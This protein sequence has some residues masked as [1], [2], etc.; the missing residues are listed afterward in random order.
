MSALAVSRSF[1]DRL[2]P[3]LVKEVRQALRGRYFRALFWLTL[4]VA[5]LI[6]LT[7]VAQAG[8]RGASTGVGRSFF[9]LMSGCLSAAVLAFTPFSAFLATSA[10]WDENTHDLLV[11]SNLRPRRIVYGKLLSALVQALLYYSTFS[12]FLVFAFLMNG[13][14]LLSIAALLV[15]SFAACTT[16]ALL[17]IAMASLSPAKAPRVLLMAVFGVVL[18]IAWGFSMSFSTLVTFQPNELRD[19]LALPSIVAFVVACL[20]LGGL[21]AAV[22]IAR[23]SHDEE[24]RSSGLRVLSA[25]IVLVAA[26]FGLWMELGYGHSEIAWALQLIVLLPLALLWLLFVCEPEALGRHVVRHVSPRP[27]LALL[28]APFLPGGGRG[29]ALMALHMLAS[30]GT[31]FVVR[32]IPGADA[33]ELTK[34]LIGLALVYAYAWIY[35]ALPAAIASLLPPKLSTRVL[36]RVTILCGIPMLV[37]LPPLAGLVLGIPS[38]MD[39]LHPLNPLFPLLEL[40][41][42]RAFSSVE[43]SAFLVA[44]VV[45]ILANTPRMTRGFAEV[46]AASRAR[47]AALAR[48]S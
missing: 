34:A 36:T 13:V 27:W 21:F 11:L 35:V 3:I 39:F 6:G 32:L 1:D 9:M 45:A 4:G 10:E 44:T 16:L 14:D 28:S 19:P 47:R 37:L 12:P 18:L 7:I 24:N 2:N 15:T 43:K 41:K 33:P 29:V 22:A 20:L 25:A 31:L 5:T 30:L 48:P 23:L 17:G 46:L 40:A 38:W 8:A 42:G 26:L